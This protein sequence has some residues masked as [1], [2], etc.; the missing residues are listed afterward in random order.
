MSDSRIHHR[1]FF[2]PAACIRDGWVEFEPAQA[3]QLAR[4]LR[5]HT[6]DQVSVFDGTGR[7]VV[8][9]LERTAPRR[10]TARI[11]REVEAQAGIG[12]AITLA[13]VVP[14]GAAMDLI[15]VKATELGVARLIPL[16]AEQSVRKAFPQSPR[17]VRIVREAAE[18]CGRRDLPDI[19]PIVSLAEFLRGFPSGMPF[20]ACHPGEG[21]RPLTAVCREL[22]QPPALTLLVG[23][24][25]GF[26]P[27]EIE[28]LRSSGARLALL[29]PR[30]LRA[31]T[32][33][34]AALAILQAC[35]GDLAV[36]PREPA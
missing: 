26:S 8:A 14:R 29:G 19:A 28:A 24:E 13:Q 9:A 18:Q 27:G 6:G 35:L 16:T 1:R 34:L 10:A 7:E 25:G 36:P 22:G 33:A 3:H 21:A 30:L 12:L 4:V 32:A 5:L 2:V 23:G 31:E 15:L 20:L 11:L 17:W